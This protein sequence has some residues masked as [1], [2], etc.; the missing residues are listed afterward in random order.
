MIRLATQSDLPRI[1]E[2]YAAARQLMAQTGNPKQWSRFSCR[3]QFP[4]IMSSSRETSL[5]MVKCSL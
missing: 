2:V 3:D 5:S 1:F 4:A